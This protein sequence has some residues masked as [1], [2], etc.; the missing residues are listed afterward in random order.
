MS[1]N[2]K[3]LNKIY[4]EN[5][6]S[7]GGLDVKECPICK[8]KVSMYS[9]STHNK[10]KKHQIALATMNNDITK[11]LELTSKS[12]YDIYKKPSVPANRV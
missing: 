6:K 10:T 4:Y 5:R 3:L 11:L 12:C 9:A 7:K 2:R 8:G 1:E